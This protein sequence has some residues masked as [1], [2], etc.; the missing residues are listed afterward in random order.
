MAGVVD[1]TLLNADICDCG[2]EGLD[3]NFH[4][5]D[6]PI[7]ESWRKRRKAQAELTA[8]DERADVS[9]R[10]TNRA[11]HRPSSPGGDGLG[12]GP[13]V[14]CGELWPCAQSRRERP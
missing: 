1:L 10:I 8:P 12:Y 3:E 9:R 11:K 6:C 14:G 4:L 5:G 7:A 2:H 13:C